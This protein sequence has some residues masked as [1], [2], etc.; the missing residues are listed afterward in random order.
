M[1]SDLISFIPLSSK[2]TISFFSL[3]HRPYLF[4]FLD[5]LPLSLTIKLCLPLFEPQAATSIHLH[6]QCQAQKLVPIEPQTPTSFT[7]TETCSNRPPSTDPQPQVCNNT[8]SIF[9]GVSECECVWFS[10]DFEVG[11]LCI[12]IFWW[13]W[14]GG[15]G[16][17]WWVDRLIVVEKERVSWRRRG[18]VEEWRESVWRSDG[19]RKN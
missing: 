19:E 13:W 6:K 9:I 7:S 16:L 15:V 18:A 12:I 8:L 5:H 3:S 10:I 11:L 1:Y 2:S 4:L 14:L 17:W